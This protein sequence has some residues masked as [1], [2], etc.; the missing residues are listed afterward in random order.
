MY[1]LPKHHRLKLHLANPDQRRQLYHQRS[2]VSSMMCGDG[3]KQFDRYYEYK[4][5]PGL[6]TNAFY[7]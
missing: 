4:D 7:K 3:A 5:M 1:A 2:V 6:G